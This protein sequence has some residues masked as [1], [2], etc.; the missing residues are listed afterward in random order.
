MNGY[1]G[2]HLRPCGGNAFSSD[3][4]NGKL[5]RHSAPGSGNQVKIVGH[6]AR[7]MPN[8]DSNDQQHGIS[9]SQGDIAPSYCRSP[10]VEKTPYIV[11]IEQSNTPAKRSKAS[12]P[13][14]R[15]QDGHFK[16]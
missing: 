13:P 15:E 8:S 5:S 11:N 16:K 4:A 3:V 14:T 10:S 9:V 12:A 7:N 1:T 6:D 2:E